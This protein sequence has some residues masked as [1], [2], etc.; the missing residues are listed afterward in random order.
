MDKRRII[1]AYHN[2]RMATDE[3]EWNIEL[4]YKTRFANL[5]HPPLEQAV[6]AICNDRSPKEESEILRPIST[7][8]KVHHCIPNLSKIDVEVLLDHGFTYDEDKGYLGIPQLGTGTYE[9][10]AQE[11]LPTFLINLI[12]PRKKG[13]TKDE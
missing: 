1:L 9:E 2:Y 4:I 6:R 13:R 7:Y 11:S 10:W 8:I 3:S 5:H 12:S